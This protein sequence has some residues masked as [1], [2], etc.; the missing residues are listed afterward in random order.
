MKKRYFFIAFTCRSKLSPQLVFGSSTL[1][2]DNNKYPSLKF[3][4]KE[5][6][7]MNCIV[8]SIQNI[9]ELSEKDYNDYNGQ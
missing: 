3:I 4:H 6:F 1:I 2:T 9:I 8:L 5:I 7:K